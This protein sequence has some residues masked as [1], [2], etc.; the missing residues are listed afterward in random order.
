MVIPFYIIDFQ[1]VDEIGFALGK[2]K[3]DIFF[4][5]QPF[6]FFECLHVFACAIS[7][8]AFEYAGR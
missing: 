1:G 6:I 3:F 7:W 2:K 8:Q 5:M 4:S